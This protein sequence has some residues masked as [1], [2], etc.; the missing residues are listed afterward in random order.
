M[1]RPEARLVI[2]GEGSLKTEMQALAETL[3]ISY[4]VRWL[5]FSRN[6]PGLLAAIDVYVQSSINEGLSL[7]I[8][9]AMAAEKA[10]VA[11]SVGGTKEVIADG[12]TGFLVPPGSSAALA[13]A[14]IATLDDPQRRAAVS[15]AAKAYVEAEFDFR[16]MVD[17]YEALYASVA[18][19]RLWV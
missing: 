3:G 4:A 8:L 14:V 12:E 1:R 7:S 10:V 2:A 15:R 19:S 9:E 11:T 18:T 16:R 5:G 17:R 6:M 13:A